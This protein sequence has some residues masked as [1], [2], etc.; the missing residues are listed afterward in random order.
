MDKN[1]FGQF[2]KQKRLDQGF[3]QKDLAERLLLDVSAVS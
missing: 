3:T 2:I 1:L